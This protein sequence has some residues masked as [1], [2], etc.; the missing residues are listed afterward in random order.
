MNPTRNSYVLIGLV[1]FFGSTTLVT[2][3]FVPVKTTK[4]YVFTFEL[5]SDDR[6]T[7]LNNPTCNQPNFLTSMTNNLTNLDTLIKKLKLEFKAANNVLNSKRKMVT[8]LHI[9][10]TGGSTIEDTAKKYGYRW[11]RWNNQLNKKYYSLKKIDGKNILNC[12][13]WHVPPYLTYNFS[14]FNRKKQETLYNQLNLDTFCVVRN[15]YTRLISEYN[16]ETACHPKREINQFLQKSI[17]RFYFNK[18]YNFQ[19]CHF[20]PQYKY[21]YQ[22][23]NDTIMGLQS[24]DSNSTVNYIP[25]QWIDNHDFKND[26]NRL[27]CKYILKQENLNKEFQ[28]LM[29]IFNQSINMTF[30]NDIAHELQYT[31]RKYGTSK[32]RS[33]KI[34]NCKKNQTKNGIFFENKTIELIQTVYKKDFELFCYDAHTLPYYVHRNYK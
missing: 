17:K 34:A 9:P 26:E 3:P 25:K 11:A 12:H 28:V 19:D 10:K 32:E 5:V 24:W 14:I 18:Q 33:E 21:I 1:I 27:T 23:W 4:Q 29:N 30:A 7:S 22:N 8:L 16:F 15:P 20:I 13:A 6:Y 2:I 31:E